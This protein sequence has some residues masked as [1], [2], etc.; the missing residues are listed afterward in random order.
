MFF[1]FLL[2][3]CSCERYWLGEQGELYNLN[4]NKNN[5]L[6]LCE[7]EYA[8]LEIN[9]S[10]ISETKYVS[11]KD[12][13]SIFIFMDSA[14]V[15]LKNYKRNR[16]SFFIVSCPE[17]ST[18]HGVKQIL[19]TKVFDVI[20]FDDVSD[21]LYIN[22]CGEYYVTGRVKTDGYSLSYHYSD[23]NGNSETKDL[24]E[25][26]NGFEATVLHS[27][28][29]HFSKNFDER[30]SIDI[31]LSQVWN[32]AMNP[33]FSFDYIV[34]WDDY[35][36]IGYK[37]NQAISEGSVKDISDLPNID[38]AV[39]KFYGDGFVLDLVL[40]VIFI[41]INLVLYLIACFRGTY[42][43]PVYILINSIVYNGELN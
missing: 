9:V 23:S 25:L 3:C 29:F 37:A 8:S 12:G 21:D 14:R 11:Q 43:S 18:S 36:R 35:S 15:L 34:S 31:V 5:A 32:A 41:G 7:W 26:E 10:G 17:L 6:V 24:T 28:S 22:L 16:V 39:C 40:G 38:S 27:S 13:Y 4:I 30:Y 2:V 19:S 42:T 1:P 20:M 33:T